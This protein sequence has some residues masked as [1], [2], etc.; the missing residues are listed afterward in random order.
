MREWVLKTV[1][2]EGAH[3]LPIPEM[4][5][6]LHGSEGPTTV[7]RL[8]TRPG[9]LWDSSRYSIR[10]Q[11]LREGTIVSTTP[12]SFTGTTSEY[13]G[14]VK[15]PED[16]ATQVRSSPVTPIAASSEC[17]RSRFSR[18]V[19]L[20]FRESR[21]LSGLGALCLNARTALEYRAPP[22]EPSLPHRHER[23]RIAHKRLPEKA[24]DVGS[25][26]RKT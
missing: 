4:L 25:T 10:A 20:Y 13:E 22:P 7:Q 5:L 21:L 14:T 12:L 9:R 17:Q 24:S 6:P 18:T 16:G 19:V 1:P 8:S 15:V 2:S 26:P 3:G 23:L 11:V